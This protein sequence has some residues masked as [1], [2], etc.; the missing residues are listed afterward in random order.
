[1]DTVFRLLT[2]AKRGRFDRNG[3]IVPEGSAPRV[4]SQCAVHSSAL[5]DGWVS[6]D[7]AVLDPSRRISASVSRGSG[8]R[9]EAPAHLVVGHRSHHQGMQLEVLGPQG[10]PGRQHAVHQLG[11]QGIV[12]AGLAHGPVEA[13]GPDL[14]QFDAEA[15][16]RMADAV[17]QIEEFALQVAAL[18]QQQTQTIDRLR[19]HMRR[20]VPAGAHQMRQAQG[21]GRVGLV[22]LGRQ[23]RPHVTRLPTD[24]R[25]AQI[26]QRRLQP[27]RQRPGLMPR[28]PQTGPVRRQ[29]LG[30]PLR[31]G[32]HRR[33]QGH[34]ALQI[35]DADRRLRHAHVQAR[36]VFRHRPSQSLSGTRRCA[37]DGDHA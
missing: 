14:G 3:G 16:Q 13:A 37:R 9:H 4:G 8:H 27:R 20:P 18:D 19:L 12:G 5:I 28:T 30:D 1:M 23:R 36:I 6:T 11:G 22:A 32:R 35:D 15:L 17:F 21:V 33:L 24:R 7:K 29:G 2:S 10:R 25:H 31:L 34:R 26:F